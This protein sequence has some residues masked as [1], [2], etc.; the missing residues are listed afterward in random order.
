MTSVIVGRVYDFDLV[1]ESS[2]SLLHLGEA[3][4]DFIGKE[5]RAVRA[6]AQSPA[7]HHPGTHG[8]GPGR[9]LWLGR[10]WPV[11]PGA[12]LHA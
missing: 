2:V 3:V 6:A 1:S 8:R 10:T 9:L 4:Y 7:R 11:D 12:L 5:Q